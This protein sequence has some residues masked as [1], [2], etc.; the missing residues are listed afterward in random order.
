[1]RDT[2]LFAI[3]V[4]GIGGT[5]LAG[6]RGSVGKRIFGVSIISVLEAGLW[7]ISVAEP[8]KR[9]VTGL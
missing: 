8:V 2:K 9:L 6:G 7:Q 1:M 4:V 3:A 5:S